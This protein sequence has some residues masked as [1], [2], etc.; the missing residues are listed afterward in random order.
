MD[1]FAIEALMGIRSEDAALPCHYGG[2]FRSRTGETHPVDSSG[3]MVPLVQMSFDK[4]FCGIDGVVSIYISSLF[5]VDGVSGDDGLL[6]RTYP[7]DSEL[8]Y[9]ANEP[10]QY[11]KSSYPFELKSVLD[12]PDD[13]N[14]PEDWVHISYDERDLKYPCRPGIKVGGWPFC[15]NDIAVTNPEGDSRYFMQIPLA[16]P[17]SFSRSAAGY[18]YIWKPGD[19]EGWRAAWEE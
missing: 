4:P 7:S 5:E 18:L 6:V 1:D 15:V 8:V 10:S 13:T 9:T 14:W 19:G 3:P 17:A 16:W 11:T 12:Y 2:G